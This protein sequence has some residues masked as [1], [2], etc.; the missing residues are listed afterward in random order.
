MIKEA[1]E[2]SASSSR[3]GYAPNC[4]GSREASLLQDAEATPWMRLSSQ[5]A[6][7]TGSLSRSRRWRVANARVLQE[8]ASRQLVKLNRRILDLG[9]NPSMNHGGFMAAFGALKACSCPCLKRLDLHTAMPC[10]QATASSSS[11]MVCS[12][13]SRTVLPLFMPPKSP[14]K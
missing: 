7:P 13:L 14:G 10:D 3:L 1:R 11:G 12:L 9:A 8:G 2:S 4:D 5:G 6:G